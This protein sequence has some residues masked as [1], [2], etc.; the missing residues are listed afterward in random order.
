MKLSHEQLK[1][2]IVD[3]LMVYHDPDPA[4][5]IVDGEQVGYL[6][7]CPIETPMFRHGISISVIV[8]SGKEDEVKALVADYIAESLCSLLDGDD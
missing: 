7:F 4:R 2:L 1:Q 3:S 5:R 6:R 8:Q